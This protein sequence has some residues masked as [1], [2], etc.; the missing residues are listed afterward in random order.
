MEKTF[1]DKKYLAY[2]DTIA[3]AF[4]FDKESLEKLFELAIGLKE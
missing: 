2:A 4:D 3:H 1:S